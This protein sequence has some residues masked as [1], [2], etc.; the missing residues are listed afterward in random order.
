MTVRE[1]AE[2][3]PPEREG[4]S[5]RPRGTAQHQVWHLRTRS[6][7]RDAAKAKIP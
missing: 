4:R 7:L 2:G 5:H 6:S 3:Q 1:G